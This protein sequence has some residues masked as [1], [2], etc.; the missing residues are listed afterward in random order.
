MIVAGLRWP[1]HS[2]Y[3]C[4]YQSGQRPGSAPE[5]WIVW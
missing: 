3:P 5:R 1:G 2:L 4:V